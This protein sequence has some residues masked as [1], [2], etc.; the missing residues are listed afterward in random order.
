M[1]V[2]SAKT[3]ARLCGGVLLVVNKTKRKL[4]FLRRYKNQFNTNQ[5]KGLRLSSDPC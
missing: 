3:E 5:R 1:L 4:G 2:E